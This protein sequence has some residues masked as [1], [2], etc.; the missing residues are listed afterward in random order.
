[1]DSHRNELANET[2]PYLL[3]HKDNPVHWLPWGDAAFA[4]ARTEDKPILLSVGYAACH[5]CHVMAHESFENQDIAHVMNELF[6]SIKV[7]RE[8]RPDIDSIYQTALALLGEHGGWP[9]TMFLTP[10]R[11]PFW[12]GTYFP[13]E[14]RHGRPAFSEI[15]RQIARIYHEDP[16]RVTKNVDALRNALDKIAVNQPGSAPTTA[17]LDRA[18]RTLLAQIDPVLGGLR[19]APKFP[20]VPLFLLLWRAFLRTGSQD[21]HNAVDVTCDR[22]CQGGIY[23]HLGG[24]FARY[25]T[26]AMWLVPHFEKMLYDNAQLIDLLTLVWRRGKSPLYAAR[27]QET[28]AWVLREMVAD[29]GAFAASFDADSEGE[30]GKFYVWTESEIDDLLGPGAVLFKQTYDVTAAGNWEGNNILHR[31][32]VPTL[33]DTQAEQRLVAMRTTLFQARTKRVAPGWDDKVLADWNGLMIASITNAAV[34]FARPAWLNA[35]LAAYDA[36]VETLD[37]DGRLYHATRQGKHADASLLDDHAAMAAAGLALFEATGTKRFIEDAARW[38][39]TADDLF[40]DSQNGGYFFT[41]HDANNLIVRTK[42]ITD[43]ATPT[44]NGTMLGVLARLYFLTGR[45]SYRTRADAL[46]RAF[47]GTAIR[48]PLAAATFL[49]N[50]ALYTAGLQVVLVGATDDPDMRRLRAVITDAAD[51]DIIVLPIAPDQTLPDT[52]PANGKTQIGGKATAYVCRH[53]TCSLPVTDPKAL[54]TQL[55]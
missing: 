51:P 47:A 17:T 7:D 26:D 36:I 10:D 52:H 14:P 46:I 23:D 15:L 20:H 43:D 22:M 53:A 5:W 2:S 34:A 11:A 42:T 40:W 38:V 8:E 13:P 1:M 30:E 33:A 50:C 31:L 39:A 37:F 41:A 18:A 19:G 45:D 55:T 24:G 12:G 32:R 25:A 28:I 3:Q 49:N 9:L 4:R 21:L 54:H 29:D 48:S 27:I 6:V 44:G 16:G 35:A